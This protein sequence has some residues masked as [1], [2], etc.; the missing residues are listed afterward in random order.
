MTTGEGLII[1]KSVIFLVLPIEVHTQNLV[2]SL[3]WRLNLPIG[4][5]RA[6][7]IKVTLRSSRLLLEE[8][9]PDR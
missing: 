9:E 6:S 5:V 3:A 1:P 2:E 8:H 4:M 7:G